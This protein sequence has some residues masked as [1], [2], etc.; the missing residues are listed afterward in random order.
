[1]TIAKEYD[2]VMHFCAVSVGLFSS[3]FQFN[4]SVSERNYSVSTHQNLT[5]IARSQ[6]GIH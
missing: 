1:M 4:Y 2:T 5:Q 3:I 6:K